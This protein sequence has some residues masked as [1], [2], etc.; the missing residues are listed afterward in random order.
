MTREEFIKI[1][2]KAR[3][4]YREEGDRIAFYNRDW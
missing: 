3:Y 1:L 4:S 2:E